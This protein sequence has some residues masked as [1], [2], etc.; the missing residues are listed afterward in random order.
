MKKYVSTT[1]AVF[2]LTACAACTTLSPA[3]QKVIAES[4]EIAEQARDEATKA[5]EIAKQAQETA[6]QAVEDAEKAQAAAQASAKKADRIFR[7]GQ[8]K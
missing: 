8:N 3:D 4:H 7:E 2:M 6:A 1:L 5:Q